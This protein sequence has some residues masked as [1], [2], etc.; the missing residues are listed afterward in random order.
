MFGSW[1][2]MRLAGRCMCCQSLVFQSCMARRRD[3]ADRHLSEAAE[4]GGSSLAVLAWRKFVSQEMD[5]GLNDGDVDSTAMTSE[6]W[7]HV[8]C[9]VYVVDSFL[10]DDLPI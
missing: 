8:A 10:C 4:P 3:A 2:M 7:P 9:V 5:G 1:E 6:D